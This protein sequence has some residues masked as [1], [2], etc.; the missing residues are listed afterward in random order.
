MPVFRPGK[1]YRVLDLA[2]NTGVAAGGVVVPYDVIDS[3]GEW[4]PGTS[5][6][7]VVVEVPGLYVVGANQSLLPGTTGN[8]ELRRN[9]ATR[10]WAGTQR[11]L[12]TGF[13][14]Q[15]VNG[16]TIEWV[17]NNSGARTLEAVKT[18]GAIA[19]IGPV[20]WT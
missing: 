13:I 8:V 11:F 4:G 17:S 10:S 15:L 18:N 12:G 20:R 3:D 19:R 6:G 16:D 9:G 5:G 14:M 2:A 1:P 7:T